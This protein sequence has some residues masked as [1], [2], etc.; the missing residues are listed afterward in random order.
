MA[1]TMAE[2][3]ADDEAREVAELRAMFGSPNG[4]SLG[5]L[6]VFEKQCENQL[7][8]DAERAEREVRRQLRE[9]EVEKKKLRGGA[10]V[11][12]KQRQMEVAKAERLAIQ[13]RNAEKKRAQRALEA[14]WEL[15][16]NE[17]QRKYEEAARVRVLE[18]KAL[19]AKLD[20][21]EEAVDAQ[22]REEG[23][24]MR[25]EV[26]EAARKNRA[27]ETDQ[28]RQMAVQV[29]WSLYHAEEKKRE[30]GE[31]KRRAVA[32][33]EARDRALARETRQ[34]KDAAFRAA[35]ARKKPEVKAVRTRMQREKATLLAQR[36][37]VAKKERANDHLV[38]ERKEQV[39]QAKRLVRDQVAASRFAGLG[40]SKAMLL[41]QKAS[42][43]LLLLNRAP[44][45]PDPG[46]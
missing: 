28:R 3:P 8:A 4:V 11:K 10:L 34:Q 13:E 24:K 25:L 32:E 9:E 21:A 20:A 7:V 18:A 43:S 2:D 27:A 30:E 38:A 12:A 17:R 31:T 22:E 44:N 46:I 39:L 6:H 35:A 26:L 36:K 42:S 1:A 15:E 37:E 14:E 41:K 40:K 45:Q 19:D 23:T 29:R 16:R 33:A 5:T